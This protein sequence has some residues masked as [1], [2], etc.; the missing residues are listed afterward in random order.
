VS[1]SLAD[2]L[3]EALGVCSACYAVVTLPHKDD[4]ARWHKERDEPSGKWT[5]VREWLPS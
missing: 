1:F 2:Y 4:H 3:P 5:H